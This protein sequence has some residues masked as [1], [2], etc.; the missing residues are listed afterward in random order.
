MTYDIGFHSHVGAGFVVGMTYQS[1]NFEV[2]NQKYIGLSQKA[3][4][5][6]LLFHLGYKIPLQANFYLIPTFWLLT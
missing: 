4:F 1:T 6:Q 3:R 5:R 2:K